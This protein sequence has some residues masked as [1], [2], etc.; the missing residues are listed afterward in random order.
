MYNGRLYLATIMCNENPDETYGEGTVTTIA[1]L[2][3]QNL[4]P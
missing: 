4:K 3:W 1:R 2:I